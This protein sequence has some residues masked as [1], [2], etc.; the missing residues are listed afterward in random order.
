MA[1]V[2][3]YLGSCGW[4]RKWLRHR[5]DGTAF[6]QTQGHAL[7]RANMQG[8][9]YL[10]IPTEGGYRRLRHT[11]DEDQLRDISISGHGGWMRVHPSSLRTIY[12]RTPFFAHYFPAM[13]QL[14]ASVRQGDSLTLFTYAMHDSIAAMFT[15]D[16]IGQFIVMRHEKPELFAEMAIERSIYAA[17][18]I[19]IVNAIFNLGPETLFPL[20]HHE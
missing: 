4:Y 3:P 17:D 9:Q 6:P 18:D 20:L 5:M 1:E 8:G 13:A 12:G 10:S 19:S 2:Y 15:D 11:F 16:I 7:C 14:Y